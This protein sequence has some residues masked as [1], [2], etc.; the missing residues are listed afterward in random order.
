MPAPTNDFLPFCPTNTGTNLLTQ[1]EYATSPYLPIGNQPGVASSKLVNKALRQATYIASQIAQFLSD[2]TGDDILDNATPAQIQA[3]M[4]KVWPSPTGVIHAFGGSVAPIG[5]LLCDGSSYLRSAYPALFSVIGTAY[6]A[7]DGSHFNVPNA[8]GVFL[9][10][11][12][13]QTIGGVAIPTVTLGATQ[14]DEFQSHQ[15][16][17]AAATAAA[18][19]SA[20]NSV[21]GSAGQTTVN[22]V[23][24]G[25]DGNPRHGTETRPANIGV[26]FIIKT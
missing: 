9:R 4:D 5:F 1:G 24:D 20:V 2:K 23:S 25:G 16:N 6:G 11:A 21:G 15:H 14:G 3:T 26:T 13:T 17:Y 7:A 10:G 8:Q 18:A 12:G 22:Y 19:G